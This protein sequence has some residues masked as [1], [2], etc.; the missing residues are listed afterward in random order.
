[1]LEY[2][3]DLLQLVIV[4]SFL[5][6][7]LPYSSL[8]LIIVFFLLT[9]ITCSALS[10]LGNGMISYSTLGTSFFSFGTTANF[11]CDQAFYLD[12][13]TARNCTGDGLGVIGTWSDS[14][15]MCLGIPIFL[16]AINVQKAFFFAVKLIVYL[17]LHTNY[18]TLF[19]YSCH[20]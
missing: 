19:L 18:N 2:G 8:C 12:G 1:M 13:P 4:S 3:V 5:N 15:P 14:M 11:S 10:S 16:W 7:N 17:H 6:L 9:A 20:L